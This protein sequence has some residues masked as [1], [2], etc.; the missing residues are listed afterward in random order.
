MVTFKKSLTNDWISVIQTNVIISYPFLYYFGHSMAWAE[1]PLLCEEQVSDADEAVCYDECNMMSFRR[2]SSCDCTLPSRSTRDAWTTARSLS[3]HFQPNH[4]HGSRS[5]TRKNF[6][7]QSSIHPSIQSN[8]HIHTNLLTSTQKSPL[9]V[10]GRESAG[11][12]SPSIFL[13]VLTTSCPCH[14]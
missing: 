10:P 8:M 2:R 9:I 3:E 13:P 7:I 14:T 6:N 4:C 12:V 1:Q 11:F 5:C